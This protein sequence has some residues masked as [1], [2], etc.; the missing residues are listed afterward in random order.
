L[1][2]LRW[3][4]INTISLS[5]SALTEKSRKVFASIWTYQNMPSALKEDEKM[6]AIDFIVLLTTA[7][8]AAG[9]WKES[10]KDGRMTKSLLTFPLKETNFNLK[11]SHKVF[12]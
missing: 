8:I 9:K 4:Y 2:K 5:G 3:K 12:G 1:Q 10:G 7:E 6:P 11:L